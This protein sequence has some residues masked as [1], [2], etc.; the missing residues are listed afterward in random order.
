M[1]SQIPL[2]DGE[3]ALIDD[4]DAD[5]VSGFRW[6]LLRTHRSLYASAKRNGRTIYMHRLILDAPAGSQVDHK[7]GH[8]LNNQRHNLRL[9]SGQQQRQNQSRSLR[10]K[11]G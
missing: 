7:D 8:G 1:V 6:Y 2:T 9:A 3:Y 5:K 11:V 10:N 4:E